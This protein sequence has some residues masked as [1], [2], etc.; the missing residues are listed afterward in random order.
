MLA[1]SGLLL[2]GS[3]ALSLAV[4]SPTSW[5]DLAWRLLLVGMG[6]GLFSSRTMTVIMGVGRDMMA[7]A[8]TVSNLTARLGT[9]FGPLIMGITWTI[10]TSLSTQIV[11]GIILVDILASATLIF[12]YLSA[13][14]QDRNPDRPQVQTGTP[15]AIKTPDHH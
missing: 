11:A 5:T 8:S 9:V 7:A 1:G 4:S 13:I 12:A 14:R 6:I 10:V 2:I 15:M 3:L